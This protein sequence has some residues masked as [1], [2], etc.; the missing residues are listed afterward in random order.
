MADS[1]RPLADERGLFLE[2]NGPDQLR[3]WGDSVKVHRIAQNLLHNALRY[4]QTGGVT[5]WWEAGDKNHWQLIV[6]DTGP[7][8]PPSTSAESISPLS[9]LPILPPETP[10]VDSV[11]AQT[12]I[13]QALEQTNS[14]ANSNPVVGLPQQAKGEGIGL[15]IVKRLC[16]LLNATMTVESQPGSGTRF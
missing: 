6:E 12:L 14:P 1:V 7:G 5:L 11:I 10:G 15:H 16:D 3:I 13:Q 8:L 2:L 9:G 4:T